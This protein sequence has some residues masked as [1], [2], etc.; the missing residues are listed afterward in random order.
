MKYAIKL[1]IDIDGSDWLYL[2]TPDEDGNP[3]V[4]TFDTKKMADGVNFGVWSNY[5]RV[6]EY[7]E[8]PVDKLTD[9]EIEELRV[10]KHAIKEELYD[11]VKM[12]M[13]KASSKLE[14][15]EYEEI[16]V[17][18]K[19]HPD[20]PH[21]FDRNASLSMD[22]YVCECEH[23]FP[24]WEPDELTVEGWD[25]SKPA[26]LKQLLESMIDRM[27]RIEHGDEVKTND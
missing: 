23:W 20:A 10:K 21:G 3:V 5:G 14:G 8:D 18:C 13:F 1:P 19:T 24:D 17:Q 9:E 26:E 16:E 15:I 11:A 4:V 22:R 27:Y 7:H 6:V 2:T 25:I 12:E